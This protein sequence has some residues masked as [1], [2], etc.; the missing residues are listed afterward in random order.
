VDALAA[1][2]TIGF[3]RAASSAS[4][5]RLTAVSGWRRFAR[6]DHLFHAGERADWVYVIT[7]GKV[8]A[9]ATSPHGEALIVHVATPG[10]AAGF[11]ELLDTRQY[12]LSARALSAVTALAVPARA[13]VDLLEAE[14]AVALDYARQLAW[15]T[16][17]LNRALADLVFLDLERRL[18]R[19][20]SEAATDAGRV[21]LTTTQTEL[22]ANL[23]V[24][25]QSLNQA[26][27]KLAR[28]GLITIE[29]AREVTILDRKGLD[30]FVATPPR[31]AVVDAPAA[32]RA[33]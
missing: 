8:A 26:L 2:R 17:A 6:G 19:R 24:A 20:L 33:P 7:G 23:G 12:T 22:A 32:T 10:E 31:S 16:G 25:R 1:L 30:A 3:L 13:V 27:A 4:L 28:R 21:T 11:V 5:E 14:P 29:S 9:V 18:A 15:I